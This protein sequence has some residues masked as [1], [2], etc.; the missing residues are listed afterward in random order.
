MLIREYEMPWR[1]AHELWA[2]GGWLVCI[3]CFAILA[4]RGA[5]S[6]LLAVAVS[7]FAGLLACRRFSR[8]FR[9]L[10]VRASLSGRAM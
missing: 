4:A 7:L 1:R 3:A 2:V 5:V 9:V 8:G 6:L 10:R